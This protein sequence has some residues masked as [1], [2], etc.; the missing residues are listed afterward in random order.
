[1]G[2]LM[3]RLVGVEIALSVVLLVL[4]GLFIRSAANFQAT[5][6]AFEPEEVYTARIRLPEATYVDTPARVRFAEEL[7][8]TLARLPQVSDVAL[9]TAVP[10]VG[11]S[12]V[13]PMQLE[14]A[15]DAEAGTGLRAR[16]IVVTPG[17]FELFHAPISA[18]RDFDSRDRVDA[19]PVA[20]V[21]E[22]FAMRHFPEGAL[23]RRIRHGDREGEEAWLT[24]VGVIPDLMAGGV[25][26]E[27]RD[28]VYL[29]LAQNAPSQLQILV[30]PMAG[31]A[32]VAGPIRESLTAL[33]PDVALFDTRPLEEVIASANSQYTWFSAVFLVSGGIA[34]FLAGLGL[35]GV[36]SF[37]VVQ[38]TREIGIRMAL[39]GRR[40][41]IVR[42][43]LTEGMGQTSKGLAAG[44][45]L[46][47]AAAG[48]LRSALFG[49][50]PYDVV[51][52]GTIVAVLVGAAWLGCWF[53]ARRATRM[54]PL[55]ALGAE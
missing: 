1:M 9:A 6:F 50:A 4:A 11:S 49:V 16:S 22:A 31:F 5:E 37:W 21:N 15:T 52:F 48:L 25:E 19:L 45:L 44:L 7:R 53:P 46:A 28:A 40:G 43:V 8:E 10:G 23:D 33:D 30:R 51:V 20:I 24:I 26:G 2:R 35:Y 34:L 27:I 14:G 29:P 55:R 13:V 38:R 36:M 42:L 18:G 12:A 17:F 39:G 47:V 32:S 41:D 3:R 54:D